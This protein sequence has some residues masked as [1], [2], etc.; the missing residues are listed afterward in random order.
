MNAHEESLDILLECVT[1][2]REVLPLLFEVAKLSPATLIA[3]SGSAALVRKIEAI[4][5]PVVK[6][7]HLLW[8]DDAY[9]LYVMGDKLNAAQLIMSETGM[10]MIE[11]VSLLRQC[12]TQ[13]KASEFSDI[14]LT[15]PPPEN[16]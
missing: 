8:V 6:P 11:V 13:M 15:P 16:D 7:A 9:N 3:A 1:G 2:Q 14:I 10:N 5:G 4:D 12:N